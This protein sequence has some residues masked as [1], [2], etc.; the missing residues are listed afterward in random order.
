MTNAIQRLF[1]FQFVIAKKSTSVD[2]MSV[3]A[4]TFDNTNTIKLSEEIY[5]Q[6]LIQTESLEIFKKCNVIILKTSIY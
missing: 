4:R 3:N 1:A 2:L 6:V 5:I